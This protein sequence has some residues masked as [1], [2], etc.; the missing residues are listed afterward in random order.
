MSNDLESQ[1]E[2]ENEKLIAKKTQEHLDII[3][4]YKITFQSEYGQVVF[5]DM[6]KSSSF[7]TST[8]SGDPVQM[9]H[10][11]GR[12]SV[13]LDII[14]ILDKDEKQILDFINKS[15]DNKGDWHDK[16]L[17]YV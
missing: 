5:R 1:E 11:E 13:I 3:R 4:A 9:A 2:S 6:M 14:K 10:N 16:A 7:T 12:R 8:Y 15:E 17:D